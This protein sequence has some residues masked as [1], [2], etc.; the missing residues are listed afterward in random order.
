[1]PGSHLAPGQL[2]G[3]ELQDQILI[4]KRIAEYELASFDLGRPRPRGPVPGFL[5]FA[6]LAFRDAEAFLELGHRGRGNHDQE[7]STSV[8]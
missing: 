5:V 4:R 6:Q 2:S 7:S 8:R 3:V 1:M